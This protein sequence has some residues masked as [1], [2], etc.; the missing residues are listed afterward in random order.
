MY[1]LQ[2]LA[3]FL[4]ASYKEN[5]TTRISFIII[6]VIK[7]LLFLINF[8]SL[9]NPSVLNCSK[10]NYM[11]RHFHPSKF[12]S[13]TIPEVIICC[14]YPPGRVLCHSSTKQVRVFCL[15]G[16]LLAW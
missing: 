13:N 5:M 6:G 10:K 7:S 15:R 1:F 9:I 2:F 14:L 16:I 3:V 4:N 8:L 11:C 12:Y